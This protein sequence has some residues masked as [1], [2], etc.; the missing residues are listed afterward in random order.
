MN[1]SRTACQIELT[2]GHYRIWND[3]STNEPRLYCNKCGMKI[4]HY[5]PSLKYERVY[6]SEV[7]CDT[8]ADNP[9]S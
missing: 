8:V 3:P 9:S 7:K 2:R 6:N 4:T 5:N 1:C